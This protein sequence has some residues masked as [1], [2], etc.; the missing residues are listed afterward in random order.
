MPTTLDLPY[1][2][3]SL[4]TTVPEE[5]ILGVVVPQDAAEPCDE[6][7][8]IRRAL[9]NPIGSR[10]LRDTVRPGQ[11]VVIVTSDLTRPCPADKLLPD[12]LEELRVAGIPDGDTTIVVA[13]GLHRQM[14]PMELEKLVGSEVYGRV[15]VVNSDPTE[16]LSVGVTSARTP[17]DLFAP[18]VRADV[19]ICL[20]NLEFHWFAGYSG[21]AKA[22]FPGCASEQGITANHAMMVKPQAEGGRLAGNP[23]RAD[24]EE[25]VAMVGVDFILNVVV[26][27]RKRIVEAVAGDVT[28]AHRRG[29]EIVR[30]RG[31]VPIPRRAE[32]VFVSAGGQPKD[33]NLYQAQKA[34]DNAA[35]AVVDGGV[36]V[37]VAECSEGY[38]NATFEEWIRGSADGDE[39][40]RRI[41]GQFVIGGHKAAA[42][43]AVQRRADIFLVSSMPAGALANIGVKQT[44]D[45]QMAA[46]T[47]LETVGAEG[48]VLAMPAGG[49]TFPVTSDSGSPMSIF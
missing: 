36:I 27:S 39:I 46:D 29:C 47:A 12:V 28:K 26:D 11:K 48:T 20:G 40:L 6:D 9:A 14:T 18:V 30:K 44:D 10:P 16:T 25:A 24:L 38:G 21:G 43:A 8:V 33:I 2:S 34:L 22:I 41:Q 5:R 32:V 49:S 35:A 15:A 3:T 13:L 4:T 17:V 42:I 23:V 19:R 45:L 37:W 31:S 1:G 7:G